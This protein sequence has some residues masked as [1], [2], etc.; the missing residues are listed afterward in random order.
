VA[1]VS[2]R[3]TARYWEMVVRPRISV[4]EYLANVV[5]RHGGRQFKKYCTVSTAVALSAALHGPALMTQ[6]T[7]DNMLS[8]GAIVVAILMPFVQVFVTRDGVERMFRK[9]A[10]WLTFLAPCVMLAL[11]MASDVPLT[12]LSVFAISLCVTSIVILVFHNL[13]FR[14]IEQIVDAQSRSVSLHARHVEFTGQIASRYV[15]DSN[16][17]PDTDTPT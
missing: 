3:G 14:V 15:G 16:T 8:I 4:L 5:R 1:K 2:R 12:R 9:L 11:E 17:R 13:Y 10:R 7:T 6:L